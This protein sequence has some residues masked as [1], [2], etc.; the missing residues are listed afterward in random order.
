MRFLDVGGK[1]IVKSNQYVTKT[2][3]I[4]DVEELLNR[5]ASEAGESVRQLVE[6]PAMDAPVVYN[7]ELK[8]CKTIEDFEIMCNLLTTCVINNNS[9]GGKENEHIIKFIPEELEEV[10]CT[11]LPLLKAI[12]VQNI[13]SVYNIFIHTVD[14]GKESFEFYLVGEVENE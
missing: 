4:D 5:K 11:V 13:N 9:R 10:N 8:H 3:V 2:F 6:C 1:K 12:N 7:V 14:K